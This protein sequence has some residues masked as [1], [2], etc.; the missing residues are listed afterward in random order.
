MHAALQTVLLCCTVCG[1]VA[2]FE[3]LRRWGAGTRRKTDTLAGRYAPVRLLVP[4]LI[5]SEATL[6]AWSCTVPVCDV[7]L[8]GHLGSVVV[9]DR[10]LLVY[11]LPHMISNFWDSGAW[12]IA[13]LM[14]SGSAVMPALLCCGLLVVWGCPLR[15]AV[16]GRLIIVLD[17]CMRI[18]FV[19]VAFIAM[20]I[21]T[22][23]TEL[24]AGGDVAATVVAEP[25]EGMAGAAVAA[26]VALPLSLFVRVLHD[27]SQPPQAGVHEPSVP[28]RVLAGT[29]LLV[30]TVGLV[31][32]LRQPVATFT[33]GGVLGTVDETRFSTLSAT[34]SYSV[35]TLPKLMY[36]S[37]D[38]KWQAV[39]LGCLILLYTTVL[40]AAFVVANAARWGRRQSRCTEALV[41]YGF[42]WCALDVLFLSALAGTLEMD[43]VTQWIVLN[44]PQPLPDWCAR[45]RCVAIDGRIDAGG[46]WVLTTALALWGLK[47]L[48]WCAPPV[49]RNIQLPALEVTFTEI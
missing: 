7:R 39:L 49:D 13:T 32:C 17:L 20:V 44:Q 25:L 15:T 23:R 41:R 29:L 21:T 22:L 24:H 38:V 9:V 14:V 47:A 40:P 42:S 37:T 35:L 2:V 3:T 31:Q 18:F 36:D 28:A 27:R 16:R 12:M 4:L 43:M 48:D 1:C 26:L 5:I 30:S 34:R 11:T 46:W 45:D 6:V 33:V 8:K 19:V 10:S